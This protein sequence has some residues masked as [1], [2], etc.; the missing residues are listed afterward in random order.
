MWS[1]APCASI[2]S[3]RAATGVP[4]SVIRSTSVVELGADRGARRRQ[5]SAAAAAT[6]AATTAA[7]SPSFQARRVTP[8]SPQPELDTGGDRQPELRLGSQPAAEAAEPE[9]EVGL[10]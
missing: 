4:A 1:G 8:R 2:S 7:T 5:R 6:T 10:G 3:T 9:V